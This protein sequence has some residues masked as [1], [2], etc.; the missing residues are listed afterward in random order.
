[1][2]TP[3]VS[4]RRILGPNF[5]WVMPAFLACKSSCEVKPPSGPTIISNAPDSFLISL[6]VWQHPV[7]IS[8]LI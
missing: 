2:A 5:T 4:V 1:M 6:I 7:L 3:A 8:A